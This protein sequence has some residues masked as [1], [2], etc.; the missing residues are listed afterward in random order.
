MG[1]A[2][3]SHHQAALPAVVVQRHL[4]AAP[5]FAAL[6]VLALQTYEYVD[7]YLWIIYVSTTNQIMLKI[8]KENNV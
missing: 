5:L 6:S 7:I 3:H 4:D 2:H 1:A 8:Y